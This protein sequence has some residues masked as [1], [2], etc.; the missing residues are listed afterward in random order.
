MPYRI[1]FALDLFNGPHE[2]ELSHKAL[3]VMLRCLTEINELYLQAHPETPPLYRSGVRYMEEPPGQED[4]QDIPITLQM[5]LADCE[6]L[7]CWRVAELRVRAGI[8]AKPV[9]KAFPRAN[10]SMLYHILVEYPD[11]TIEDPS[12]I[13]GMR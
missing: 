8:N 1:T 2:R 12:R 11:G 10:G 4:W 6:D 13:L 7:V 5:G 9:F 3:F